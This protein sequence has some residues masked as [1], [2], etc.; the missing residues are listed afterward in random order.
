MG[1]LDFGS[2]VNITVQENFVS[3]TAIEVPRECV[4]GMALYIMQDLKSAK[5]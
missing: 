5:R 2:G 1:I 4:N 3:A